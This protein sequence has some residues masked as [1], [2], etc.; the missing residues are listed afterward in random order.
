MREERFFFLEE[1]GEDGNE[2]DE[3]GGGVEMAEESGETERLLVGL[4]LGEPRGEE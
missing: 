1:L 4:L 3:G 2:M